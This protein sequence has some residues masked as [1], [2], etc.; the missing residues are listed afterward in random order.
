MFYKQIEL[1]ESKNG[2]FTVK[3]YILPSYCENIEP[4]F[5][6]YPGVSCYVYPATISDEEAKQTLINKVID[7]LSLQKEKIDKTIE[8]LRDL[9]VP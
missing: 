3:I 7:D 1:V 9:R 6:M 5:M 4:Y 8:K 2:N